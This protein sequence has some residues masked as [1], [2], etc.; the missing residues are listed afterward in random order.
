MLNTQVVPYGCAAMLA[1]RHVTQS[2][3]ECRACAQDRD[4]SLQQTA[5]G[6][7]VDCI[8]EGHTNVRPRASLV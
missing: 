4:S 7:G 1:D 8:V 3:L 5:C 2:E 6:V